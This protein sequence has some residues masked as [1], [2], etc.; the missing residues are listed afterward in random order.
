MSLRLAAPYRPNR[1]AS[2][3]GAGSSDVTGPRYAG[4]AGPIGPGAGPLMTEYLLPTIMGSTAQ[5]RM[6][7]AL[8]IGWDVDWVR[9][10]ERAIANALTGCAWHL[11]DPDEEFIEGDYPDAIALQAY[12]LFSNPQGELPITGPDGIGK[13]QSRRQQLTITTRHL[14]IAG[15]A[16]WMLDTLDGNG[17]PHAIL[18]IR[19]DRLDPECNDKGVLKGWTLDKSPTSQGVPLDM[20]MVRL[21]QFEPPDKGVFGVGLIE[22]SVAKGLNNGLIDKHYTTMLS[23]GGRISG[24]LAPKDGAITDDG[25]YQ[26]LVNDWRNIVEQPE[27]ARRL[28]I[29]RAPI[30]FT[31]TVQSVADMAIIDLMQQNRDALLALWGVPLTMLNG[32]NAGSTGLNGGEARKYDEAVLWQGAVD[33]RAREIAETIQSILDLW[34]PV[35]G[36]APKFVWDPP[37]FD[38]DA[39]MY[40]MAGKAM[41]LPLRNAERR[42]IVGLEPF[43]DPA[44]D[45]AIWMPI[46]VTQMS[47]APDE[48]TG[49][50][51][52]LEDVPAQDEPEPPPGFGGPPP[53]GGPA[54]TG[55]VPPGLM[56]QA[57]KVAAEAKATLEA[58]RTT[59]GP[60]GVRILD[61]GARRLR[62]VIDARITPKVADAL[63]AALEQQGD[64]I[65]AAVEKHWDAITQHKGKDE[66]IWWRD[67]EAIARALKPAMASMAGQVAEHIG[68]AF[69]ATKAQDI[70]VDAPTVNITPKAMTKTVHRD[71]QGRITHITEEPA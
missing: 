64:D 57:E 3:P 36:W 32:Q 51:P 22:S 24:I 34:E 35:L 2:Q 40:E 38:N 62:D 50:I 43:G 52:S 7:K 5:Q 67:E 44:L 66:T 61:T 41:A 53:P 33:G 70:H 9:A 55:T 30:E 1:V 69:G 42:A 23:S 14:G 47:M 20:D 71:P 59:T 60:G 27:A 63:A 19:P 10:A 4:K 39:P 29:V 12:D 65:A 18:Y 37:T 56:A 46:N 16:A 31:S 17:L 11:E 21:L 54:P 25:V 58:R 28:Q 48:G 8:S 15:S 68:Q 26:Q 45:N 6:R 13:R 49:K